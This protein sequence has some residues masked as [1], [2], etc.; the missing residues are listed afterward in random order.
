MESILLT[1]ARRYPLME[2]RDAVKLLYQSEFGGGH[3]IHDESAFRDFLL[4]E[5]QQTP[6][7]PSIPLLEDIGNGIVRVN[8]AALDACHFSPDALGDAFLRSAR[9]PRGNLA[10]FHDKLRQLTDLTHEGRMP[11]TPEA[12]SAYL[13]G[14][15]LQGCPP[16]SHSDAYR[17]AYRPAY[18][19]V[20]IHCLPDALFSHRMD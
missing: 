1:H 19:V 4:R 10:S 7:N 6:R 3:L 17:T 2:P 18:R 14:Y 11:F 5:Y 12:L 15:L 13:E 20:D 16:V 9:L 8:L